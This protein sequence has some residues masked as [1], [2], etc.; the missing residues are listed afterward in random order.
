MKITC[1]VNQSCISNLSNCSEINSNKFINNTKQTLPKYYSEWYHEVFGSEQQLKYKLPLKLYFIKSYHTQ[2]SNM[3]MKD[4]Q[5][6][7]FDKWIHKHIVCTKVLYKYCILIV[8]IFLKWSFN[9]FKMQPSDKTCS[10][11]PQLDVSYCIQYNQR[12]EYLMISKRSDPLYVSMNI[13]C[14][15]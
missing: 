14:I 7:T 10:H 9:I 8:T 4:L 11:I 5:V 6:V 15:L 13:Y 1:K 12:S 3:L 2:I